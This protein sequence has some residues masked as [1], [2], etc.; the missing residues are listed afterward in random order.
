MFV[1]DISTPSPGVSGAAISPFSSRERPRATISTASDFGIAGYSQI[2]C[3]ASPA[4]AGMPTV[5]D[6]S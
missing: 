5:P 2:L 6:A 4:Y 1:A 3:S